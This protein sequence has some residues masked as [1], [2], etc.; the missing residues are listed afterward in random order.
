MVARA[1][2]RAAL[3]RL[4]ARRRAAVVLHE[5]EGLP[6]KE[7]ARVLGIA[8]VTV[9]WHLMAAHKDLAA[10]LAPLASDG[11]ETKR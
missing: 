11:Q 9:R 7:V 10:E 4:P 1:A 3:V 6:V 5:L 2:I 8:R